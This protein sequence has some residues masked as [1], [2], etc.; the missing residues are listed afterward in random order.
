MSAN[1][2]PK[3]AVTPTVLNLLG[4]PAGRDMPGRVITEMLTPEWMR[5]HPERRIA[6]WEYRERPAERWPIVSKSDDQIRDK[7]RSLGYIE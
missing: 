5:A 6:T 7:L 1:A 4:L 2:P 3:A